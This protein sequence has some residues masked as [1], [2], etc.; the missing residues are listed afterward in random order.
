MNSFCSALFEA[1]AEKRTEIKSTEM[2]LALTCFLLNVPFSHDS[3]F[4]TQTRGSYP[5]C[6][7][8]LSFNKFTPLNCPPF[9][10]AKYISL[11]HPPTSSQGKESEKK[12]KKDGQVCFVA[13]FAIFELLWFSLKTSLNA[14]LLVPDSSECLQPPYRGGVS[15]SPPREHYLPFSPRSCSLGLHLLK[16]QSSVKQGELPRSPAARA[17][18]ASLGSEEWRRG[19]GRRLTCGACRWPGRWCARRTARRVWGT[20]SSPLPAPEPVAAPWAGFAPRGWG[21]CLSHLQGL[22]WEICLCPLRK[23]QIVSLTWHALLLSESPPPQCGRPASWR[24]VSVYQRR[25]EVTVIKVIGI[26]FSASVSLVF[27]VLP[28]SP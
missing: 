12:K 22:S 4:L 23:G 26:D 28:P 11:L 10:Q 7:T 1:E 3:V 13:V 17:K 14:T 20:S 24:S 19:G 6:Q 8:K 27:P 18:Q 2:C 9:K 5:H 15:K 16:C 25:L 21:C